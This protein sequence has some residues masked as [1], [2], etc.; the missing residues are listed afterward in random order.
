MYFSSLI[1]F[2]SE[3]GTFMIVFSL[4]YF[5][6]KFVFNKTFLKNDYLI[7]KKIYISDLLS[8]LTS[9]IVILKFI[10]INPIL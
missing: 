9:I 2:L 7:L 1:N 8:L 5:L 10:T 4:F 3:L 6:F